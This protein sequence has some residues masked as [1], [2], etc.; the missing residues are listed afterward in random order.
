MLTAPELGDPF[1]DIREW[2]CPPYSD[3]DVA[4]WGESEEKRGAMVMRKMT[5]KVARTGQECVGG[6]EGDQSH[7]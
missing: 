1:A 2:M 5:S 3:A 7:F 6:C 4:R